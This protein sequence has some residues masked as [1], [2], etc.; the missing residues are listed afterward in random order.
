MVRAMTP[1]PPI[2]TPKDARERRR[3]ES[4]AGFIKP[5]EKLT[6]YAAIID[7]SFFKEPGF[8]PSSCPALCRAST[9]PI[10]R[11]QVVDCR[12]KYSARQ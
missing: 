7:N 8:F 12:D 5:E 3:H 4:P 1:D 10:R 11:N 6:N 9:T 2:T